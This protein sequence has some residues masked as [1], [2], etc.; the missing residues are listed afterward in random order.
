[1]H[2]LDEDARRRH[3]RSDTVAPDPPGHPR[4]T[5]ARH[6][7]HPPQ[8]DQPPHVQFILRR[9]GA[10]EVALHAPPRQH[11]G[12]IPGRP[13]PHRLHLL[14]ARHPGDAREGEKR[15]NVPHPKAHPRLAQA[16]VFR[17]SG[18]RSSRC[19]LLLHR[20]ATSAGSLP[21]LWL[22]RKSSWKSR[23]WKLLFHPRLSRIAKPSRAFCIISSG[24]A[25]RFSPST[26]S[27]RIRL[28]WRRLQSALL[29]LRVST[30]SPPPSPSNCI[31]ASSASANR[32]WRRITQR[33]TP[34]YS[35]SVA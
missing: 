28:V 33:D 15:A 6:Q 26:C 24:V 18:P 27:T 3:L 19:R 1:M 21:T 34:L 35:G 11:M 13:R 30:A 23:W 31:P 2:E 16:G 8:P 20:Q 12:R 32:E 10:P 9:R 29:S 22:T 25:C 7:E 17:Q 14:R 4:G 5:P